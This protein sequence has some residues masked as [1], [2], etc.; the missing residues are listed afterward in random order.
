MDPGRSIFLC[1]FH[2][3]VRYAVRAGGRVR[4]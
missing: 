3:G 1:I 4:R 2:S